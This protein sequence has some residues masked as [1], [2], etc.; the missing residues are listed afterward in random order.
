MKGPGS[1][2]AARWLTPEELPATFGDL[3]R[4]PAGLWCL[5]DAAALES[6]PVQHVAIVGTREATPYGIR[7]A[8]QLAA[9]AARA[10]L[11]V[12]SG[13]ARG[14]DAA[15]HRAALQAGGRTIGVQGTGVDVPYPASHR[16]LHAAL[17]ERGTVLSEMEPGTGATPGCFP[18]RNRLIAALCQVTVVVEAPFKSGAINTATQALELGRTVAA[19]PGRVDDTTAQGSNQLIRDGAQV[20][21]E[22]ADLLALFSIHPG[23]GG[24][25]DRVRWSDESVAARGAGARRGGAFDLPTEMDAV[26][27]V[28]QFSESLL[29]TE[30]GQ[31]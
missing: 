27:D 4:R 13:L 9:A 22:V 24:N 19:V 14:I 23:R 8:E 18:R 10:G 28:R 29:R 3:P 12:V 6:A 26:S 16:A 5:G 15:A 2:G 7:I 11:V 17:A 25:S 21:A 30:L 20:I 31:Q 1:S